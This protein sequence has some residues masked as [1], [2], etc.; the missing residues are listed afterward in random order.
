MDKITFYAKRLQPLK[1]DHSFILFTM[2]VGFSFEFTVFDTKQT[3]FS[4]T[5][6]IYFIQKGKRKLAFS[7]HSQGRQLYSKM[8]LSA[9][10]CGK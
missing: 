4:N 6:Q 10:M 7:D 8:W 1:I 2:Y 9:L 3:I 5:M